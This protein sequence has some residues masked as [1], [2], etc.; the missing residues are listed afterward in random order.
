MCR[1][2]LVEKAR[3]YATEDRLHNFRVAAELQ[4]ITERAALAGMMAKHTVSVYDLLMAEACADIYTW[5]EKVGDHLNYLFLLMAIVQDE[6]ADIPEEDE[7][8]VI[9]VSTLSWDDEEYPIV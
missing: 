9:E 5:E 4:G 8:D 1:S 3:E 6:I 7:I 2:V